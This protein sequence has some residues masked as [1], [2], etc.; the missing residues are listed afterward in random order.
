MPYM[1][2]FAWRSVPLW[3]DAIVAGTDIRL[4]RATEGPLL[5]FGPDTERAMLVACRISGYGPPR[6]LFSY[7]PEQFFCT[8]NVYK[9]ILTGEM[10]ALPE[11]GVSFKMRIQGALSYAL[12]WLRYLPD[13]LR[14]RLLP[15][16]F[17]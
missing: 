10:T 9:D 12:L 1:R 4:S 17:W 8:M 2:A 3:Q 6:P 7:R 13:N 15:I 5:M 11:H 16:E 14:Y